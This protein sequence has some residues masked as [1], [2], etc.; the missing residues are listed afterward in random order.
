MPGTTDP[1]IGHAMPVASHAEI[2]GVED[3][4]AEARHLVALIQ[5]AAAGLSHEEGDP[6]STAADL[7]VRKLECARDDL[8]AWRK[9]QRSGPS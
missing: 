7:A 5:M 4:M 3:T 6:I 9:D 1:A 8:S 2:V